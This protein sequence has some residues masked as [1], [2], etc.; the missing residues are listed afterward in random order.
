[1]IKLFHLSFKNRIAFNYIVSGAILIAFVF[2]IIYNVVILSVNKHI[3]QE[4]A[5]ELESHLDDIKIDNH[6]TYLIKINE[7]GERENNEVRVNPVFV[8]FF[9]KNK[10]S[11]DKT[12][13]LN[14]LD[15]KLQPDI[16]NEIFLDSELYG[17]EIRQIQ[18]ILYNKNKKLGYVIVAMTTDDLEIVPVLKNILFAL[19]PLILILLFFTARYFAGRSI[20]PINTIIET[21]KSI[22]SENLSSRII[23]PN[24]KDELH[25]LSN[26]INEL[27]DRIENAVE[28]EKQFTSDASHELRTPLAVLKGT[29][30][31]LIRKPREHEE[32]REKITFCVEEIDRLNYLLDQLLL[33]ARFENQK[34]NIKKGDIFLNVLLL[35]AL[36]LFSSEINNKKLKISTNLNSESIITSDSY[37]VGIILNNLISNAIK[38]SSE[39]GEIVFHKTITNNCI[40]FS[41][42]DN[43][44]GISPTDLDKIF[45]SFFRSN[46]ISDLEIKGSGIGLSIVKR[47]CDLLDI[48]ISVLSKENTGT[49]MILEFKK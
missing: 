31:V 13:N 29:L 24:N 4:I 5:I 6:E 40:Q 11:I 49:T 16:K 45:T 3:N 37:L 25:Q 12:P 36:T 46:S 28:R 38:Y 21:S 7:W 39:N 41:I 27:L 18:R 20:K 47:L 42:K 23:L 32:Y 19:F 10:K 34:Q 22:T 44:I 9:D 8:E 2:I 35:D 15:L 43:G 14:K 1:M 48:K 26:Q 17:I 30:E 33:L